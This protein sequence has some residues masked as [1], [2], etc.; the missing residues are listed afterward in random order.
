MEPSVNFF[1]PKNGLILG[2]LFSFLTACPKKTEIRTP[3]HSVSPKAT[4]ENLPASSSEN[5]SPS[6]NTS[7][8]PSQNPQ[9][10]PK[11]V[12]TEIT[13]SQTV[14]I[15]RFDTIAECAIQDPSDIEGTT[16][17]QADFQRRQ[18]Q[19]QECYRKTGEKSPRK[20][21]FTLSIADGK[22]KTMTY[23]NVDFDSTKLGIC[24][25]NTVESWSFYNNCVDNETIIELTAI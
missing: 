17:A 20:V 5:S 21:V 15:T 19:I 13:K 9:T 7:K 12:A 23:K 16:K 2:I 25:Q 22:T 6:E 10:Q 24:I 1:K 14:T 3:S 18:S 8:N 4:T 11:T